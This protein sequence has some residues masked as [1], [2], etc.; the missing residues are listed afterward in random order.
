MY[1]AL[2]FLATVVDLCTAGFALA[3]RSRPGATPLAALAAGASCWALV[4][5]LEFTQSGIETMAPWT[6]VGLSLSAVPPAVWLVFALAYTGDNRRVP[7]W[8]YPGLLVEPLAFGAL[9][10]TNHDHN[11]VWTG[12]ERITYTN[13]SV[14]DVTYGVG[15]GGTRPTR[16][17]CSRWGRRSLFRSL[18]GAPSHTGGREPQCWRPC[19]SR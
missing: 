5:A 12:V 9:V 1:F 3:Y 4:E 6:G 14:L 2:V 17:C 18:F 10:W 8:L 13:L 11:L 7:K 15:F 16:I 19:G